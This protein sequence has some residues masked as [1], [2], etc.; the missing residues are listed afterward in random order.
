[1]PLRIPPASYP[2]HM[3]VRKVKD[4][5]RIKLDGREIRLG[6]ALLGEYVGLKTEDDDQTVTVYF[7][8][9]VIGTIDLR[10]KVWKFKHAKPAM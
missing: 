1:M 7:C 5:G 6:D 4:S 9:T 8:Q 10:E 2:A 3:D